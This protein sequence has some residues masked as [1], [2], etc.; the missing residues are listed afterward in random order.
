MAHPGRT[1]ALL[2][3]P[4]AAG[5]L[6]RPLAEEPVHWDDH[7][8]DSTRRQ[9][10]RSQRPL[11]RESGCRHQRLHLQGQQE[12]DGAQGLRPHRHL[13]DFQAT[14]YDSTS[15][16]DFLGTVTNT[17][18]IAT[19]WGVFVPTFNARSGDFQPVYSIK[20]DAAISSLLLKP[21]W[22]Y[23][24]QWAFRN[25]KTTEL[26]EDQMADTFSDIGRDEFVLWH[27]F[28]KLF[29]QYVYKDLA[30]NGNCFG[31][32]LSSAYVQMGK[33]SF[34]APLALVG[35]ASS[36]NG[37]CIC[38]DGSKPCGPDNVT[39]QNVPIVRE[40]ND[41]H[42]YQLNSINGNQG[43]ALFRNWLM[44]GKFLLNGVSVFS[45]AEAGHKAGDPQ[46][47]SFAV[48][49]GAGH[50][51]RA[52]KFARNVADPTCA[53]LGAGVTTCHIMYIA[54]PNRPY[55]KAEAGN[56]WALPLSW[57]KRVHPSNGKWYYSG[58]YNNLNPGGAAMMNTPFSWASQRG[59]SIVDDIPWGTLLEIGAL[60]GFGDADV[61]ITDQ[62]GNKL[63]NA[64]SLVNAYPAP[65]DS[66]SLEGA[67]A[68]QP[69]SA[70]GGIVLDPGGGIRLNP[71]LFTTCLPT[72]YGVQRFGSASQGGIQ[73]RVKPRGNYTL[74][75]KTNDGTF[76][77]QGG[78]GDG[79]VDQFT[80]LGHDLSPAGQQFVV[81][82]GSAKTFAL[83][84]TAPTRAFDDRALTYT[85]TGLSIDKNV[86]VNA[87]L[88]NAG[89]AFRLDTA[90]D[91]PPLKYDLFI[92]RGVDQV[93]L[94][95]GITLS[96]V[97]SPASGIFVPQRL[98]VLIP[99][100]GKKKWR[101]AVRK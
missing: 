57:R 44:S 4:C 76:V 17:L 89:R 53:K 5:R 40:T 94:K 23:N 3:H 84:L 65:S 36:Q 51:V 9:A 64:S 81:T 96:G 41:K 97:Q 28:H 19:G 31:M 63:G 85:A 10:Q 70:S 93:G 48:G 33:S 69:K 86:P 32:A 7:D 1:L 38:T 35:S 55:T 47:V 6:L 90:V 67:D 2:A 46:L 66:R 8:P 14:D 24:Y 34:D 42:G 101:V 72:V 68:V 12:V 49:I 13:P 29:Y 100:A 74:A 50:T 80:M 98:P 11:L 20:R 88:L 30:K 26:S 82:P 43:L 75:F 61:D 71:C 21:Q 78:K 45:A 54:D 18:T 37:G 79:S 15:A 25:F 39:P 87:A 52:Y 95:N 56:R 62:A 60:M 92:S 16:D 73:V 27:P 58:S 83:Q 91:V 59:P 99:G 22:R 77:A